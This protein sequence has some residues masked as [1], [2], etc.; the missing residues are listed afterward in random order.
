[1]TGLDVYVN[2]YAIE[3]DRAVKEHPE[4]LYLAWA[5]CSCR[6]GG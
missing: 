2:H 4:D 6:E 5:R 1:M 3:L